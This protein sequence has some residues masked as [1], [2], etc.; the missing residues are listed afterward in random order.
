MAHLGE[1]DLL[2]A[3]LELLEVGDLHLEQGGGG[4][5]AGQLRLHR[6]NRQVG[7]VQNLIRRRTVVP[8]KRPAAMGNLNY[9]DKK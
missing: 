9:Y 6:L 7:A 5:D 1:S 3:H 2:P 8:G 4:G